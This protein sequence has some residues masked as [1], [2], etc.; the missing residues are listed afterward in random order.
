MDLS[1]P[2]KKPA[3][4]IEIPKRADNP[5]LAKCTTG[6]WRQA[7]V[8]LTSAPQQQGWLSRNDDMKAFE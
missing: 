3:Q 1:R 5:T 8:A 2:D 6:S 4:L 7:G